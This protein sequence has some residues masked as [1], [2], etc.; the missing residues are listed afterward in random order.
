MTKRRHPSHIFGLYLDAL[1][2][3]MA[4]SD[5]AQAKRGAEVVK[6]LVHDLVPIGL[7]NGLRITDVIPIIHLI[8]N[9]FTTYCF[10][11]DWVKQRAGCTGIMIMASI[12][13]I[14]DKFLYI[15]EIDIIRTLIHVL[16]DSPYDPPPSVL[17][18]KEDL[19]SLLRRTNIPRADSMDVDGEASQQR[20]RLPYLAGIFFSEI[21]SAHPGV[22]QTVQECLA[23]LA[24]L[25]GKT[26]PDLGKLVKDRLHGT[27][28]I[29]P[30]RALNH[31]LVIGLVDAVRYLI[32]FNPPILEEDDALIRLLQEALG[33]AENADHVLI[34]KSD[35]RKSSL[36]VIQLRVACLK[37]LT[38]A[39]VLTENFTRHQPLRQRFV[40][41][42]LFLHNASD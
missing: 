1:P 15:R 40:F 19:L 20:S 8:A 22:R 38:N 14:G 26:V 5:E 4:R 32:G 6:E 18:I 34:A 25:F 7:A 12:P 33:L 39:L 37:L 23:L 27:I 2:A 28:Y 41:T 3:A 9:R 36:E 35:V 17:Q 21:S 13:E 30:L 24:S 10:E 16:K 29:K 11:S 31:N 42:H